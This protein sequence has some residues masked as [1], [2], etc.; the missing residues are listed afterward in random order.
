MNSL[1]EAEHAAYHKHP[2]LLFVQLLRSRSATQQRV[3]EHK[4]QLEEESKAKA[5]LLQELQ[6]QRRDN[7]MLKEQIE[8]EQE[9]KA[10]INRNLNKM[11]GEVVNWRNKYEVDAIQRT[12]ELEDAKKKLVTRLQSAEELVESF[13]SKCSSLDKTKLRL[14]TEVEDMGAELDR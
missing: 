7:D 13:Q 4:R 2:D 1:G 11:N 6:G 8:D 9:S 5:C 12:E 3:D 14:A 10:E